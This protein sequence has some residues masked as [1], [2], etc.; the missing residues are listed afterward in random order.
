MIDENKFAYFVL[1]II[2]WV[3]IW[4]IVDWT[5]HQLFPHEKTRIYVQLAGIVIIVYI[6]IRMYKADNK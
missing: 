6:L 3:F 4:N 2:L 5:L 1:I